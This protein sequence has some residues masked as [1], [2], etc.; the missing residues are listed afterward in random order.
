MVSARPDALNARQRAFAD[1]YEGRGTGISAARAAGYTGNARVLQVTASKL[2]RHP[3]IR[4]RITARLGAAPAPKLVKGRGRGTTTERVEIL[5]AMAR[6]KTL[7]A[8][9]RIA[10]VM[11]AADLEGERGARRIDP[12]K[13]VIP[14]MHGE[15]EP[16]ST[17]RPRLTLVMSDDDAGHE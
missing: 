15:T 8:K 2:L 9:E 17:P 7:T 14:P 1:A 11:A 10:A 13:P 4:A 3:G 5:M 6:D 12:A 16:T